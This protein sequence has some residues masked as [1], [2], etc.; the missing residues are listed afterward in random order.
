ME[1]PSVPDVQFKGI[2]EGLLLTLSDL[3]ASNYE[4]LVEQIQAELA[5]KQDFLQGSRVVLDVGRRRLGRPA[6]SALQSLLDE[7]GLELWA[8]L[9]QH[10]GTRGAARGMGLGTRLPGSNTDLEGN[11]LAPAAGAA[12]AEEDYP[13]E[14]PANALLLHETIRSGQ[15][16][17]HEG[18]VVIVG[19]V[20]PGAEVVAAGHVI[21]WGRLRG[22]VHAGAHGDTSAII[23]AL[24]V[25]PTQLRIADQ[26]AIPPEARGYKPLPERVSIRDG[27]IVADP[28]KARD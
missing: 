18:H 12:A 8:V 16:I 2:R 17:F 1:S 21:V 15:S 25:V 4:G 5:Q 9:A 23:C 11:R 27:Q 14:D 20:N 26:I 19:D 28:W 24:E 3:P 13:A 10:E 7:A 6:L 22:L